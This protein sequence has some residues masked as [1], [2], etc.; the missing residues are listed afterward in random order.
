LGGS[1][2]LEAI[3]T[4]DNKTKQVRRPDFDIQKYLKLKRAVATPR[5]LISEKRGENKF[6]PDMTTM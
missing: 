4:T 2:W 5:Y 1:V 3:A 6:F